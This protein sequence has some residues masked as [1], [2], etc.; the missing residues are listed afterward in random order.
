MK[1]AQ[2]DETDPDTQPVQPPHIPSI[3]NL[4][5]FT[6][7]SFVRKHGTPG[8]LSRI[9]S[10][11]VGITYYRVRPH[12]TPRIALLYFVMLCLLRIYCFFPLSFSG[13]LRDRR[14]CYPVRLRRRRPPPCQS[15]QAS[16]PFDHQISPT[17]LYTACI[18]VV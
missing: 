5:H 10:P 14:C 18:R 11:F 15:N 7:G 16:P 1:I 6:S 8:I 3:A 12:R 17:L 2:N 9:S 4:Q 13:R